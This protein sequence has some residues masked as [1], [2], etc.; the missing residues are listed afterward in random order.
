MIQIYYIHN[1]QKM[2]INGI[3]RPSELTNELQNINKVI[4]YFTASWC[5]PCRIIKPTFE[6][7]SDD[8]KYAQIAFVQID[9]DDCDEISMNYKIR[10]VPTFVMFVDGVEKRRISGANPKLLE[11]LLNENV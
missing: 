5:G 10:S 8:S 9:I 2:I 7:Y 1:Y 6:K 11:E 3:Q 4:V